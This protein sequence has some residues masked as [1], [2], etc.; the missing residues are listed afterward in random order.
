MGQ[1]AWKYQ[2]LIMK[3]LVILAVIFAFTLEMGEGKKGK[4][5]KAICK[6][7]LG[8]PCESGKYIEIKIPADENCPTEEELEENG[9]KGK[10]KGKK[11]NGKKGNTSDESNDETG[12]KGKGKKG[13][14][15]GKGGKGKNGGKGGKGE[16]GGKFG[17]GRKNGGGDICDFLEQNAMKACSY[18]KTGD[19]IMAIAE[20]SIFC[21]RDENV[22]CDCDEGTTTE[23]PPAPTR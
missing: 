2:S 13:G 1:L 12:G 16:K 17:K 7:E 6:A 15:G 21:D 23:G 9:G 5:G 3:V 10:G 22:T 4:G 18:C 8:N 11:G 19:D 14:K 20:C